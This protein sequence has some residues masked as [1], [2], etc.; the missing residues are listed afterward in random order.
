MALSTFNTV[1]EFVDHVGRENLSQQGAYA[2]IVD[3]WIRGGSISARWLPVFYHLYGIDLPLHL[4]N[5]RRF[6]PGGIEQKRFGLIAYA[7]SP[8]SESRS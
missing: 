2:Q 1:R 3:N 6:K 4:F 5:A 8:A 7:G